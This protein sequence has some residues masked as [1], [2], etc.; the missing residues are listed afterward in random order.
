MFM[1]T[2]LGI[3]YF[4]SYLK[5]LKTSKSRQKPE[6]SLISRT[7]TIRNKNLSLKVSGSTVLLSSCGYG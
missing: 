4:K 7:A 1:F 6:E 3:L 5:T 2:L